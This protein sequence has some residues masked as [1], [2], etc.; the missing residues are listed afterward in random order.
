MGF[1]IHSGCQLKRPSIA[2]R[3]RADGL[4]AERLRA[5]EAERRKD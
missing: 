2:G 1:E 5:G 4:R 3:L